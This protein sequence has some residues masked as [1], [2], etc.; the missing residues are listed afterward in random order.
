MLSCRKHPTHFKV[1][2]S[3]CRFEFEDAVKKGP[4]DEEKLDIYAE[5]I[6]SG[7][8][9]HAWEWTDTAGAMEKIKKELRLLLEEAGR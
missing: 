7:L 4:L 9:F 8:I 2:C 6:L 1:Y 3:E 5:T